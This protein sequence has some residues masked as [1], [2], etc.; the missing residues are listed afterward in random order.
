VKGKKSGTGQVQNMRNCRR[1]TN[2]YL[3]QEKEKKAGTRIKT[4]NQ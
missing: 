3:K 2:F 1:N 4:K